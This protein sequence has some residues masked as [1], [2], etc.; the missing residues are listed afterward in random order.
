MSKSRGLYNQQDRL[1]HTY[2]TWRFMKLRT[3]FNMIKNALSDIRTMHDF[4]YTVPNETREE[5]WDKECISHP[6]ASTCKVY[7]G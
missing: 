6:T 7:E 1:E 4:S 2:T 5:F 3:P